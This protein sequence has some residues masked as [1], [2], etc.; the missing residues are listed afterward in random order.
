MLLSGCENDDVGWS[1]PPKSELEKLH[2]KKRGRPEAKS[3]DRLPPGE[4]L[5]GPDEFFG[6][7]VPKGMR[8]RLVA[9]GIVE[10]T[11][12]VDFDLLADYTKDRIAVRHAEMLPNQLIYRNARILGTQDKVFDLI[13]SR[14]NSGTRL[15]IHEIT[16]R[17]APRGLSEEERWK[18]AGLKPSGGLIDPRAME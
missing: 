15:E 6:F 14:Q 3:A 17:P 1:G 9:P 2:A 16:K 18:R 11:G 8:G 4:L 7:A 12:R 13:V 5:E 10:I